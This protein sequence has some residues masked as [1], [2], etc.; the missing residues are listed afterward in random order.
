VFDNLKFGGSFSVDFAGT[1]F[2]N[3]YHCPEGSTNPITKENCSSEEEFRKV[4]SN[5]AYMSLASQLPFITPDDYSKGLK[6]KVLYNWMALDRQFSK[7]VYVYFSNYTM[8]TDYGWILENIE[9]ESQ[10]MLTRMV[11]DFTTLEM[12][13]EKNKLGSFWLFSDADNGTELFKRKY[14]R[15]QQL[16]AEIGGLVNFVFTFG[17]LIILK[18]NKHE[19]LNKLS[20]FYYPNYNDLKDKSNEI[21]SENSKIQNNRDC[22]SKYKMFNNLINKKLLNNNNNSHDK[23]DGNRKQIKFTN[24]YNISQDLSKE[25]INNNFSSNLSNIEAENYLNKKN[26]IQELNFNLNL[27]KNSNL[28]NKT[29]IVK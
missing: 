4:S 10:L 18:Y 5:L 23:F 1:I 20:T 17:G 3:F 7:L 2:I 14:I 16:V 28:D 19:Y 27:N 22:L 6:T 9:I 26:K 13:K 29:L 12:V 15:I 11:P 21:I 24:N 8:T 25:P